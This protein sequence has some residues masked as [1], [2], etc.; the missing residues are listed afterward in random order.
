MLQICQTASPRQARVVRSA[1]AAQMPKP[2]DM[3]QPSER[4]IAVF[5]SIS[6]SEATCKINGMSSVQ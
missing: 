3:L 6:I 4:L 2:L 5:A 1:A